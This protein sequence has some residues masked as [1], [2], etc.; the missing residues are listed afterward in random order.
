[1][2]SIYS[3]RS[4]QSCLASLEMAFTI[5]R[6]NHQ[7]NSTHTHTHTSVF[8]SSVFINFITNI[9]P[10][11]QC[12]HTRLRHKSPMMNSFQKKY[13]AHTTIRTVVIWF[14]YSHFALFILC[15]TFS[16]QS[17]KVLNLHGKKCETSK[18]NNKDNNHMASSV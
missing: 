12:V 5:N 15:F 10:T 6:I 4:S 18:K 9:I 14:L 13:R 8:M 11:V 7:F 3:L 16:F 1:M 17:P 2:N